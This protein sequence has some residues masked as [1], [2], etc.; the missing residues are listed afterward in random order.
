MLF[1]SGDSGALDVGEIVVAI[2]NP[3]GLNHTVSSGLIS[4]KERV[5]GG[6][7]DS[8]IDYLQTDSAINPGSSGGPLLN[9]RGE[10]VGI[11]TAIASD[12]SCA[13]ST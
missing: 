1:R 8:L 7:D 11:N 12:A 5:F 13:S 10:V 2:G 4:A 6:A 3:L 9:L